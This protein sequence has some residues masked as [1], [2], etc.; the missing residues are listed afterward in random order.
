MS[1]ASFRGRIAFETPS[2]VALGDLACIA[3]FVIAGELSHFGVGTAVAR[4]PGTALPFVIGWAVVAPLVGGYA[5]DALATPRR[6]VTLAL[7]AWVGAD[8]VG[9]AL[10]ATPVFHGGF[11]P[12][13]L[14]VS[15]AVGGALLAAWRGAVALAR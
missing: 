2:W 13:F 5:A 9:Q 12:A 15:L 6:A 1:V 11:S 10:R 8:L 3:L 7:V 14:A 4:A